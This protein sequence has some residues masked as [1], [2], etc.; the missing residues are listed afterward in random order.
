M[1]QPNEQL[2]EINVSGQDYISISNLCI[3][4]F[5][6]IKTEK[7]NK[8]DIAYLK[9]LYRSMAII[10]SLLL[11]G[12]IC[13]HNANAPLIL[14]YILVIATSSSISNHKEQIAQIELDRVSKQY[15]ALCTVLTKSDKD[16]LHDIA[17]MH[18]NEIGDHPTNNPTKSQVETLIQHVLEHYQRLN[19]TN[20]A[21]INKTKTEEPSEQGKPNCEVFIG[22]MKAVQAWQIAALTTSNLGI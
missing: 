16:T 13:I 1:E 5:E 14:S 10:L 20:T 17:E 4:S 12:Q 8:K 11:I 2:L 18:R 3:L 6:L 9:A 22:R 21:T 15:E 7:N 19:M